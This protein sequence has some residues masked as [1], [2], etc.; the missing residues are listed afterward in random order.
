MDNRKF[1]M[2]AMHFSH[3]TASERLDT[4]VVTPAAHA[5]QALPLGPV[6]ANNGLAL[7]PR[8][9]ERKECDEANTRRIREAHDAAI[10]PSGGQPHEWFFQTGERAFPPALRRRSSLQ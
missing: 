7:A 9:A 3:V 6:H 8:R 10:G 2:A 4:T 5:N 1:V